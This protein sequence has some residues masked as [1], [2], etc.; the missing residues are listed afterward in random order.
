MFFFFGRNQHADNIFFATTSKKETTTNF[1]VTF[2]W[3]SI[4]NHES[5]AQTVELNP[6]IV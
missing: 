4:P 5:L 1:N 2:E 3:T 6:L